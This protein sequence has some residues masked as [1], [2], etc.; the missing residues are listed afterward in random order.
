MVNHRTDKLFCF[1]GNLI[2]YEDLDSWPSEQENESFVT[3]SGHYFEILDDYQHLVSADYTASN[4]PCEDLKKRQVVLC[5]H[6]RSA[7]F[8][9]AKAAVKNHPIGTKPGKG[10][11][12]LDEEPGPVHG[13]AQPESRI[14]GRHLKELDR[15]IE[16]ETIRIEKIDRDDELCCSIVRRQIN[17]GLIRI[18]DSCQC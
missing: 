8:R 1:F 13:G 15:A 14:Y 12:G 9:G 10:F 11:D 16:V 2:Q 18:A 5:S 3:S 4:S 7:P 6:M 17:T